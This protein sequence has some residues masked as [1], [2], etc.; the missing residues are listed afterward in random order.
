MNPKVSVVHVDDDPDILSITRMSLEVV[1][2]FEVAQFGSGKALLDNLEG[3]EPDAF[4]LD[5]MMPEMD[6]LELL[7]EL[8]KLDVYKD[9]P[10]VFMTA[11]AESTFRV[12]L[13]G[14]RSVDCIIKPFDPISLPDRLMAILR[15]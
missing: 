1:G 4:L 6:G 3:L 12:E 2:N 10:A 11:K 7:E 8:R 13:V 15:K 9:T 5:V 14:L